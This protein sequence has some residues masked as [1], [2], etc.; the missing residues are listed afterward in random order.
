MFYYENYVVR[1]FSNAYYDKVMENNLK[2][3]S[4]KNARP[5]E[6]GR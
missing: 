5:G 4:L 3:E 2:W 1:M 6:K